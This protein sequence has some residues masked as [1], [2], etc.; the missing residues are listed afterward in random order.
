MSPGPAAPERS[1]QRVPALDGVRGL[2]A[3]AVL[4]NHTSGTRLQLGSMGVEVFFVLSGFL[5]GGILLDTTGT[6]GWAGRFYLRRTLRIWPLYYAVVSLIVLSDPYTPTHVSA[7][8]WL[9]WVFLGNVV[10]LYEQ[11]VRLS[12]TLL[13]SVAVEEHFYL[14]LPPIVAWTSRR[15][16]PSALVTM[17][18]V[19]V[20]LRVYFNHTMSPWFSY[21]V[22]FCRL[23]PL[24][25]GV[26]AAWIHRSRREWIGGISRAAILLAGIKF[27]TLAY[28]PWLKARLWDSVL[29]TTLGSLGSAAIVLSLANDVWPSTVRFLSS[30]VLVLLGSIS[31]GVYLLHGLVRE[32]VEGFLPPAL[33]PEPGL[34]LFAIV[35]TLTI[36]ASWASS[37]FFEQPILA[38]SAPMRPPATA[39]ASS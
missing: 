3:L 30:R 24:C 17:A 39:M 38:L 21:H 6:P 15:R 34:A 1:S 16:L 31:Y 19:S 26:L 37:R 11:A 22:T 32:A 12:A 7:P 9:L 10:P 14:L 28:D 13:W 25:W 2:A 23:D 20:A 33:H 4:A 27:G 8:S 18:V 35:G 5:I 29:M 36:A